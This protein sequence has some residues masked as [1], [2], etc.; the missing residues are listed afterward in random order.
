MG[1]K[2]PWAT[3]ND[4]I[5]QINPR[6]HLRM[7]FPKWSSCCN[8]RGS[9]W[10][11]QTTQKQ[12][13]VSAIQQV[14]AAC[15]SQTMS[16]MNNEC[17]GGHQRESQIHNKQKMR[18]NVW[19]GS[20]PPIK[21]SRL[22]LLSILCWWG[23]PKSLPQQFPVHTGPVPGSDYTTHIPGQTCCKV[24][25]G[26]SS[27]FI[28]PIYTVF[29]LN[30]NNWEWKKREVSQTPHTHTPWETPGKDRNVNNQ[31]VHDMGYRQTWP[32]QASRSDRQDRG[33]G[34]F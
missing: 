30:V 3:R 18:E 24:F 34:P 6:S 5:L 14:Q 1:Y 21:G 2:L 20:K 4:N 33:R 29:S 22:K 12:K 17:D 32:R 26:L 8:S 27:S 19:C 16:V 10:W 28:H 15:S 13:A 23:S 7:T 11:A 9:Y 25:S 31:P